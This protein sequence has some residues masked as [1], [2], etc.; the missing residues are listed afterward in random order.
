[1]PRLH[2]AADSSAPPERVLAAARD[3]SERRPE[4]WPNIDP[5]YY[6]VHEVGDTYAEVTE[7]TRFL[8]SAWARERYDW[9]EPGVVRA[10]TTD[11]N[12]FKRGS[13][14]LTAT[15]RDGGSRVEVINDRQMKGL[16]GGVIGVAMRLGKRVLT[17][18][19]KQFLSA[20]ESGS[21]AA[22]S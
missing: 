10:T 21:S 16:K 14:Q 3:F 1:M 15:P 9:S 20:V 4:L 12:I 17:G 11:S 18:H 19:L 6:E 5:K 13:W 8:G 2:L 22:R 7:G